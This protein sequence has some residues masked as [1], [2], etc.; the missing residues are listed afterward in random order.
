LLVTILP[1]LKFHKENKFIMSKLFKGLPAAIATAALEN[2]GISLPSTK[3]DRQ[4]ML[5]SFKKTTPKQIMHKA[6]AIGSQVIS[7]VAPV[8]SGTIASG[9][10]MK[11]G[12]AHAGKESGLTLGGSMFWCNVATLTTSTS[13]ILTNTESAAAYYLLWDPDNTKYIPAPLSTFSDLFGRFKLKNLVIDYIPGCSTTTPGTLCFA[14]FTD[15]AVAIVELAAPSFTELSSSSNS[16]TGPPWAPMRM[17]I[18][19]DNDLRFTYNSTTSS[20][21][22]EAEL[23]QTTA[24]VLAGAQEGNSAI[25]EFGTI[26]MSF[27]IELFEMLPGSAQNSFEKFRREQS[28]LKIEKFI[29]EAQLNRARQRLQFTEYKATLVAPECQEER[30]TTVHP[31]AKC[32]VGSADREYDDGDVE[33]EIVPPFKFSVE[34]SSNGG[35]AAAPASAPARKDQPQVGLFR[36]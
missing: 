26:R 31:K 32:F 7:A 35:R 23:R 2:Y 5:A 10:L 14:W 22:T 13:A 16:M 25:L 12:T 3:G 11:F 27:E 20:L 33:M 18:P 15:P 34:P 8:S 19:V 1:G 30:K 21:M 9:A 36:S 17:K 6:R 29:E 28:R 24:G 4:A